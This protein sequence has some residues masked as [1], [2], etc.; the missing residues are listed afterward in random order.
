MN[1]E[2]MLDV[3]QKS[4]RVKE[5]KNYG[6]S[7]RPLYTIAVEIEISVGES[8]DT[9]HKIFTDTGLI[10]RETIP[11]DVVSNFRGS[12]DNKPFY[13]ALIVHEGITKKYEVAARDTGGF[14][15]TRINYEP[16]VSPEELRLAHPAEFPRMGIEVE[17]WELHNYKHYFMLLIAS[18]RYESVDMWVRREKGGEEEEAASEFTVLRVNLAESELKARKVPCSWY[19]ERLSIFKDVDLKEEVRR[20]IEAG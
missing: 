18:K 12:A 3:K 16:V 10:T 5:L 1:Q 13:S 14:L 11:F 9:L 8:P 15:R 19:L 4:V 6:S 20:K 17:E 2:K 7:R